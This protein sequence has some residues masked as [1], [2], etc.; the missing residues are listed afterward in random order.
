MNSGEYCAQL[1]ND[2]SIT[3]D[4]L[5]FLNPD[6]DQ[7]CTTL[8]LGVGYC[9]K[10]VG[11]ITAY[12]GYPTKQPSI[13]FTRPTTTFPVPEP[14]TLPHAPGTDSSCRHYVNYFDYSFLVDKLGSIP[15]LDEI[16]LCTSITGRYNV[17]MENF[18]KWNPSLD[19][20]NCRL[21]AGYSYCVDKEGTGRNF[22]LLT[23]RII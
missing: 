9:V 3:L 6:L 20:N 5:F 19:S 15:G 12:P 14:T 2:N 8:Q 23:F 7:G 13:V 11:D 18:L 16:N 1:A 22:T 21:Q 10:P 4:D 17:Y